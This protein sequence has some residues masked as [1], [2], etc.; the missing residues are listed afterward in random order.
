M[1]PR[2]MPLQYSRSA[3]FIFLLFANSLTSLQLSSIKVCH[4]I[5]RASRQ[6]NSWA[7]N[8]RG[9]GGFLGPTGD[10]HLPWLFFTSRGK[11]EHRPDRDGEQIRSV[12]GVMIAIASESSRRASHVKSPLPVP[13]PVTVNLWGFCRFCERCRHVLS[14]S[15]MT[16]DLG[17]AKVVD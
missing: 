8:V 9:P 12:A 10:Q 7:S 6:T 5:T 4:T 1:H 16:F 15:L 2:F 17:R 11:L 14:K 13:V 3:S